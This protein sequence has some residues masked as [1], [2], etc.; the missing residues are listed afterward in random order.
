[1]LGG[2]G[3]VQVGALPRDA[4]LFA[5]GRVVMEVGNGDPQARRARH[6]QPPRRRTAYGRRGP[7]RNT[8][9]GVASLFL[10]FWGRPSGPIGWLGARVLPL[11]AA[12]F[13]SLM[14]REL[15]L[16]P[17]DELLDVGCGAGT[18]LARATRARHVAGLDASQIQVGLAR[19]RLA[20]RLA[21]GTA[22]VVHGDAAAL[23]WQDGTFSVVTSVNCLKFLADPDQ[24]LREMARVLRP[25]GRALVVIE[26][27]VEDA[28]RTG[29]V[30]A[31]GER[32]WSIADALAMMRRA[33][34]AQVSITQLPKRYLST[35][36][37]RGTKPA[38][39]DPGPRPRNAAASTVG[40]M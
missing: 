39:T 20:D 18:L 5:R 16:R 19:R 13:Y 24:G 32:A 22:E 21:A 7:D 29:T 1:V 6:G 9:G 12:H 26:G 14:L 8:S 27:P 15:Q 30:N 37:L 3:R 23:P 25:G 35:Q 17:E 33:G 11:V 31:L 28:A 40:R 4:G 34:F 2:V 36:L 10:A 38:P